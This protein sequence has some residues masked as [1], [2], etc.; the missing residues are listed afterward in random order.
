MPMPTKNI[1]HNLKARTINRTINQNNFSFAIIKCH[2]YGTIT[3][4]D[5][6]IFSR[7][8]RQTYRRVPSYDFVGSHAIR[9]ESTLPRR[10]SAT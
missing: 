10:P 5:K 7:E 2:K 8:I 1:M 6:F 9:V 4:A 3:C